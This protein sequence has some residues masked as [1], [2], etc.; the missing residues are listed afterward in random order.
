MTVSQYVMKFSIANM[1]KQFS[2]DRSETHFEQSFT[3]LP[4]VVPYQTAHIHEAVDLQAQ[5]FMSV[6]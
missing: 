1:Q 3:E 6:T 5:Y 2:R 4:L